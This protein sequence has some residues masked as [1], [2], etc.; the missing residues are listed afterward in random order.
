M[1]LPPLHA[2]AVEHIYLSNCPSGRDA[3]L[4]AWPSHHQLSLDELT[5]GSLEGPPTPSMDNC[6]SGSL[7]VASKVRARLRKLRHFP[8]GSQALGPTT[9]DKDTQIPHFKVLEGKH[10]WASGAMT[11]AIYG[12]P[13]LQPHSTSCCVPDSQ[14]NLYYHFPSDQ[15]TLCQSSCLLNRQLCWYPQTHPGHG[16]SSSCILHPN[17]AMS[18]PADKQGV[19]CAL[20]SAFLLKSHF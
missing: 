8:P 10:F 19:V 18:H 1:A 13:L 3:G 2:H 17:Q 4:A 5:K 15:W 12:P 16:L 7:R 14:I 20:A 11:T 6:G 9:Q